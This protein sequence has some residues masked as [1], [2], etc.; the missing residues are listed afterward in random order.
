M[1]PGEPFSFTLAGMR[2]VSRPLQ[3]T[4]LSNKKKKGTPP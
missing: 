3:T 2:L 1:V 4:S